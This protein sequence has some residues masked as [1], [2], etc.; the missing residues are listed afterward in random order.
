MSCFIEE[1]VTSPPKSKID[2]LAWKDKVRSMYNKAKAALLLFTKEN[3]MTRRSKDI[4][5]S[6]LETKKR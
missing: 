3:K 4:S 6:R 1:V 5:P 2:V